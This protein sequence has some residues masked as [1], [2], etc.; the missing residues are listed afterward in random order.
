M[1]KTKSLLTAMLLA[2]VSS[3]ALAQHGG[4]GGGGGFGQAGHDPSME[5][6]QKKMKIQATDGQRTQLRTCFELS[7]RLRVQAAELEKPRNLSESDRAMVREQWSE[8]LHQVM[9]GGHEAFRQSL[10]ADQQSALKGRLHSMDKTWSELSSRVETMD[11]DLAE[12][13]PDPKRLSNHAK[14]LEKSL[15]KWEKQH[16]ELASQMGIEG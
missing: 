9:K 3:I 12:T 4:H 5:D 15:K 6:L 2:G 10:N 8:L 1:K 13:A 16:G 14:E 11:R 7:E